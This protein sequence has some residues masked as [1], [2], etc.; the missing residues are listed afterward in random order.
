MFL[1]KGI[2]SLK[3]GANVERLHLTQ[4]ANNSPGGNFTFNL[5]QDFFTNNPATFNADGPVTPTK[6]RE[7]IFGAYIQ[8]DVHLRPNLTINAGLRYEMATVL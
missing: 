8:D 1:T 3:F 7:T 6:L 2:H 5:I 4:F